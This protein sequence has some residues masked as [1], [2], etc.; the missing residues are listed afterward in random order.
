V[1]DEGYG[2]AADDINRIFDPFFTTKPT[3]EGTG[4]GLAVSYGIVKSHG[5]DIYRHQ[6]AGP[7]GLFHGDPAGDIGAVRFQRKGVHVPAANPDR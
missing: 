2:I 4:L 1:E 7:G 6:P 5:G 3:G